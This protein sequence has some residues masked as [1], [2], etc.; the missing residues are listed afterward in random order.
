[1]LVRSGRPETPVYRH[2]VA[3]ALRESLMWSAS[4]ER[5]AFIASLLY[6]RT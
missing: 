3:T 4:G 2:T 5:R 1:M 6:P